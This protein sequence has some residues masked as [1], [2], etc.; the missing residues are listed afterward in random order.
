MLG[1]VVVEVDEVVVAEDVG[2]VHLR[3]GERVVDL[4]GELADNFYSCRAEFACGVGGAAD[5]K[6]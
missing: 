4:A 5:C 6:R 1:T 3:N 2:L